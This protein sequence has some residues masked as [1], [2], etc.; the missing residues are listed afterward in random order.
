MDLSDER[1]WSNKRLKRLGKALMSGEAPPEG[2]P[3]YDD[4]MIWHNDLAAAVKVELQTHEWRV[5]PPDGF[6]V[7]ARSKTR[8]TLVQKLIR[9][10]KRHLTL[11]EVQDLAGVRVDADFMLGEQLAFANEVAEHFGERSIVKDIRDAPHSGY[12]AVHVWLRLPCGN[13]E[14]QI[15]TLAQS[16]WANTYERLG[17]LLGRTIR[18]GAIPENETAANVVNRL[19]VISDE[20]A[21][22]EKLEQQAFDLQEWSVGVPADERDEKHEEMEAQIGVAGRQAREWK[23]GYI[24]QLNELRRILDGMENP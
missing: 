20:I 17:D 18:Y 5:S 4:V 6:D 3:H 14:V 16:V 2:C 15:R 8:D 22:F 7:T 24:E 1:P 10:Q 12:R 9:E 19:H 13:V 21:S 23:A 11:D